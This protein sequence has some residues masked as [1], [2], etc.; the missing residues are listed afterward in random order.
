MPPPDPNTPLSDDYLRAHADDPDVA[1]YLTSAERRRLVRL[2]G[3]S[4]VLPTVRS[5]T[6]QMYDPNAAPRPDVGRFLETAGQA[7]SPLNAIEAL[8]NTINHPINAA[9]NLAKAP[10]RLAGD[11][12][13]G[14][15]S[16]AMGSLVPMAVAPAVMRGV[17]AARSAIVPEAASAPADLL[18]EALAKKTGIDPA[19]LDLQTTRMRLQAAKSRTRQAQMRGKLAG[20]AETSAAP[21]DVSVPTVPAPGP[22]PTPGAPPVRAT[23]AP[24]T[25]A[26]ESASVGQT[27]ENFSL[28]PEELRDAER[29]AAQGATP[30]VILDRIFM[31]RKL[32][33]SLGTPTPDAM[34]QAV[35]FR[36]TKGRWPDEQ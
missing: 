23:A 1:P 35:E 5:R 34:R 27:S 14:D 11:V 17:G 36:N 31:S 10:F 26:P 13:G 4:P 7:L 8:I 30:Q 28:S 22:R 24:T 25:T 20:A 15:F 18:M 19:A 33:S 6:G 32:T 29:W 9:V 2:R 21:G 16:G 3:A 12:I